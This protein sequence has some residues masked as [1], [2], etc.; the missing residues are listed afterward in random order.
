M[1]IYNCCPSE[2]VFAICFSPE[3]IKTDINT[4]LSLVLLLSLFCSFELAL[5]ACNLGV[6]YHLLYNEFLHTPSPC[7][8]DKILCPAQL[9]IPKNQN[10]E[11]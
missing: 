1:S 9:E 8:H 4:P 5:F 11:S 10:A 6:S 2:L 3:Q 7:S